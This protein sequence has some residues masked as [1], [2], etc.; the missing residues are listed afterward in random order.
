MQYVS[1]CI[2][3][4]TEHVA[5]SFRQVASNDCAVRSDR[6]AGGRPGRSDAGLDMAHSG[7][8]EKIEE[9]WK[10]IL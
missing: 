6:S 1:P 4:A 8:H 7:P 10:M 5:R 2:A 3:N 9:L